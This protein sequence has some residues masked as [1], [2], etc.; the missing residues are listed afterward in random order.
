MERRGLSLR[1][2]GS[3]SARVDRLKMFGG[4]GRR[5]FR[6]ESIDLSWSKIKLSLEKLDSFVDEIFC[7][8]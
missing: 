5:R 1:F 2:V 8:R 3:Y 4:R 7:D 6:G